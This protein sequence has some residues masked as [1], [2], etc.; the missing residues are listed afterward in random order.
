MCHNFTRFCHCG[1]Y[2]TIMSIIVHKVHFING[3]YLMSR[4]SGRDSAHPVASVSFH[5]RLGL[6]FQESLCLTSKQ[7]G[8]GNVR[9]APESPRPCLK[10]ARGCLAQSGAEPGKA[11]GSAGDQGPQL[12][13]R[14]ALQMPQNL[15]WFHVPK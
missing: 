3:L 4:M 14:A 11:A 8:K 7:D 15:L 6:E 9:E 2:R 12:C 10:K 1:C 5:R 13:T